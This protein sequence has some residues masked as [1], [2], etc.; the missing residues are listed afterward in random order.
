VPFK[1]LAK[2]PIF[3]QGMIRISKLF[4]S[5]KFQGK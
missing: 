4:K 2:S 1:K 5:L 3:F